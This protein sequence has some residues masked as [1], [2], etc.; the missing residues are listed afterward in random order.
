MQFAAVAGAT[1]VGS[2]SGRL[3][4]AVLLLHAVCPS[5]VL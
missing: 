5:D 1:L 3:F 4:L 2:G